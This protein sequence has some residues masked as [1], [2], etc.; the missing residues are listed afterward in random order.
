LPPCNLW[1]RGIGTFFN[2]VYANRQLGFSVVY[3]EPARSGPFHWFPIM[4]DKD[5]R[6]ISR[7]N[8]EYSLEGVQRIN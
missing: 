5:Y 1:L 2:F 4:I 7:R 8:R 6:F 3:F